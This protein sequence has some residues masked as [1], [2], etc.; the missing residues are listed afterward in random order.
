MHHILMEEL[1][2]LYG[3]VMETKNCGNGSTIKICILLECAGNP[4][5]NMEAHTIIENITNNPIIE[6]I[7]DNMIFEHISM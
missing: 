3:I 1:K 4:V 7:N 6:R 5:Q 2:Q